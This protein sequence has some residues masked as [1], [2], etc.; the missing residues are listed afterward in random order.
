MDIFFC[1]KMKNYELVWVCYDF[2]CFLI[3]LCVICSVYILKYYENVKNWNII[4][5]LEINN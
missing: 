5:N 4:Y 3:I 1:I 2:I